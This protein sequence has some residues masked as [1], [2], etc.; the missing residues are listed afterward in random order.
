MRPPQPPASAPRCELPA[1]CVICWSSSTP[2]SCV[3]LACTHAM[4]LAC[5]GKLSALGETRCPLCSSSHVVDLEVLRQRVAEWRN[6]YRCWRMGSGRGAVGDISD[7]VLPSA[8]AIKKLWT[9]RGLHHPHAGDLITAHP[10]PVKAPDDDI[11]SPVSSPRAAPSSCAPLAC[12]GNRSA[13]DCV[14]SMYSKGVREE[15]CEAGGE[16]G[17]SKRVR[18]ELEDSELLQQRL[19]QRGR[20]FWWSSESC[21]GK[22]HG[23]EVSSTF[24]LPD[25]SSLFGLDFDADKLAPPLVRQHSSTESFAACRIPSAP[26]ETILF[27]ADVREPSMHARVQACAE[28]QLMDILAGRKALA[29]RL[30]SDHARGRVHKVLELQ[31][32]LD[33][34]EDARRRLEAVMRLVK[35]QSRFTRGKGKLRLAIAMDPSSG[36]FFAFCLHQL[37]RRKRSDGSD[38]SFIYVSEVVNLRK[39]QSGPAPNWSRGLGGHLLTAIQHSAAPGEH[40]PIVLQPLG[41]GGEL[42]ESLLR[43]YLK[44]GM[45]PCT[46]DTEG[47]FFAYDVGSETALYR[48]A[49]ECAGNQI[50]TAPH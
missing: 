44:L 6:T 42:Q 47:H 12:D 48:P 28:C 18:L 38:G 29:E 19:A 45:R 7:V 21:L 30:S 50:T 39:A 31:A 23:L 8:P 10:L 37:C 1:S 26:P 16:L 34:L 15:R 13:I 41:S 32:Q 11:M 43:H 27:V 5:A 24:S 14:A 49:P 35:Y 46:S 25:D 4:C 17:A 33:Q 3:Q 40:F 2:C 9:R 22:L 20:V 36:N